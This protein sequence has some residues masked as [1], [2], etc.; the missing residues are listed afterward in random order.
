MSVCTTTGLSQEQQDQWPHLYKHLV[1]EIVIPDLTTIEESYIQKLDSDL[2]NVIKKIGDAKA[3]SRESLTKHL[4]GLLFRR[5]GKN[6]MIEV[7]GSSVTNLSI[8]TGDLDLCLSFKNKTPRKVLRKIS[9]LLH[10]EGMEDIQLIPKARIPIVKFKDP[11]SGLDVDISLDNRLAIYNSMM[12]KSYAQEERLRL[13]VQM[14]KY[15]ASRR[16]INNAFEGSLSSY[17]WTL[18]TIQ[19]A[20]MAQPPLA[21]NRQEGCPSRPLSFHGEKYD[22]GFDDEVFATN[23]TQS[24]GSLLISFFDR[25]ATRWD[26]DSMV[27]SIRNGEALSTKSKKWEHT[28]PLPLEVVTGADDGW[29]EH[30]MPIEDPFDHEHDLSRV[31]RAEG[32]MSIQNEFMRAINML[33]DGKTWQEICEPVFEIDEEPDDLFHDLRNSSKDEVASRLEELRAKLEDVEGQIR[34]LVEERQ[35]SKELLDILRGGLRETRNVRSDRQQILSELRPLSM[36]VQELR[37]VRDG[38]NQRVAIPTKRIHQEMVRIFEKLT[39]EVDVFNAPTLGVERGDFAYFFE[40]QAMYEASLKSNEAHQEFIRLRR[41][42]NEEYRALKKTK[43]REEDV[44]VKLVES[45][46]ALE[47]VHLNP[48]SV[49]EFQKNAKLLQRSI[50][51]QYSSKHELRREIGRLEAWQRISSK[52]NRNQRSPNR[53]SRDRRPRAPD[54]NIN[55]VRQK[56]SSGDSLSL[57]ELDAL[58]SKGG[59]ASIGNSGEQKPKQKRRQSKKRSSQR[60]DI[61]QGRTRGRKESRK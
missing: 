28:G 31:V 38:I 39:S 54:V 47:S 46:P 12:L 35:N 45:N 30:V 40:L 32:A 49:K 53:Q 2:K 18:L 9:G 36:K 37:E 26:W 1:E 25:F 41:E 11:R 56:A 58:L 33:S 19:H 24:L 59:I 61:R 55:E 51:E 7:F 4:K 57:N 17:A 27:V 13:L 22:V 3:R 16:G 8:G 60:I 14:V 23:N 21:P 52:K 15:W 34:D 48:K 6:A 44:L 10:E 43:K 29:M 5:F 42:Q 50:N 20:Q